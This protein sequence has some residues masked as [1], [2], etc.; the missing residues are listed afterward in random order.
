MLILLP[1]YF[2]IPSS[3]CPCLN[4]NSLYFFFLFFFFGLFSFFLFFF[5][6]F[7]FCLFRAA[8]AAQGGS[9]ATERVKAIATG[10]CQSHSNIK[11]K[12][13]LRPTPQSSRQ[14]WILNPLSEAR[15]WPCILMDASQIRLHWAK[16]GN[17]LFLD[18]PYSLVF[19]TVL[20]YGS[21][22]LSDSHTQPNL[23]YI[24]S[25][26]G[27]DLPRHTMLFLPD[28][29]YTCFFLFLKISDEKVSLQRG[30]MW[31]KMHWY[32]HSFYSLIIPYHLP[33]PDTVLGPGNTLGNRTE[34]VISFVHLHSLAFSPGLWGHRLWKPTFTAG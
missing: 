34:K 16:T 12:P 15:D 14:H 24:Q 23:F 3:S 9:Q 17:P 10:L 6:F 8:P 32:I 1:N 11:S 18:L 2:K 13:C 28:W 4:G 25:L 27:D 7:F 19:N 29:H 20:T 22:S 26:K 5:F 31:H 30:C 33:W 21:K